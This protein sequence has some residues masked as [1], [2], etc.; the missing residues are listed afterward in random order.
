M[1][2][3]GDEFGTSRLILTIVGAIVLIVAAALFVRSCDK[4]RSEAAQTRVERSQAE[5]Q[6]NSAV[7]AINTVTGVGGNTAVSEDLGRTNEQDIRN[8]E[9]ASAKVGAGVGTAGL[10]ALCK[11]AAYRNDPKCKGVT[12]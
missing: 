8:A 6:T 10:R 1:L 7:D 11:R 9:G 4:R 3:R 12:P 2:I 5:A